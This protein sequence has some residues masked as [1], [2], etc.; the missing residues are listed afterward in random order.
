MAG[1]LEQLYIHVFHIVVEVLLGGTRVAKPGH[2]RRRLIQI[3]A[4]NHYKLAAAVRPQELFDL[5]S[6]PK[7]PS[8]CLELLQ[9]SVNL[10]FG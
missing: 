8:L 9:P 6:F 3:D 7:I 5:T 1:A 4:I 10:L 2:A